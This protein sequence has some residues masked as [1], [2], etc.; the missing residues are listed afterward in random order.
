MVE[1]ILVGESLGYCS[2]ENFHQGFS[3]GLLK[4]Q[5]YKVVLKVEKMNHHI[6]YKPTLWVGNE[7][8]WL[9]LQLHPLSPDDFTH[10]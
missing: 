8:H 9:D 5:K 6:W 1:S 10:Y 7:R 2:K 3:K 4:E